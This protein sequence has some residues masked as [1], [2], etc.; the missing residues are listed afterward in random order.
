MTFQNV[1][2]EF[3][4]L[5]ASKGGRIDWTKR[6]HLPKGYA[7]YVPG[8]HD[9]V[10]FFRHL[11]TRA[12]LAAYRGNDV[13]ITLWCGTIEL[14]TVSVDAATYREFERQG[15]RDGAEALVRALVAH[16]WDTSHRTGVRT[17]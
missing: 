12:A 17:R 1:T 5:A 10:T 9:S 7:L 15:G 16:L 4:A 13:A 2:R 3:S 14:G 11:L 8:H 6:A